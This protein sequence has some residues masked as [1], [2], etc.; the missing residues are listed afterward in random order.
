MTTN[1]YLIA[2]F[3]VA[4]RLPDGCDADILLPSFRPFRCERAWK[5]DDLLL[6]FTVDESGES[7]SKE[8]DGKTLLEEDLSDMG[9]VALY[10]A[11]SG[12]FVTVSSVSG[13]FTHGMLADRPFGVVKAFID[14]TD[15]D[16]GSKVSSLI[17]IAYSLAVLRRG[18]VAIHA[19]AVCCDG[20]AF[21]FMGKSGTGKSTHAALW[22]EYIP[23]CELLNDDNPTVRVCRDTAIAYGTPWSGKTSCYKQLSFPIGGM[24]RLSQAPANRFHRKDGIG[25]FIA[26]YPGCSVINQDKDMRDHLHDTL[27]RLAGLVRVGTLE[28]LPDKGAVLLCHRELACQDKS[29]TSSADL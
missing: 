7:F 19:S 4:V 5:E 6:D 1:I 24:V 20:R 10:T 25:A 18:A 2:D 9:L 15:R 22:M 17:R 12:Y 13:R 21:L 29:W 3:I 8:L 28:C 26:L 11:G 27:A 23:G 14:W 16:A